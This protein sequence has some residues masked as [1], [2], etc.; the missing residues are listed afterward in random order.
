[1]KQ[2]LEFTELINH[3]CTKPKMWT[4]GGSY[5]EVFAYITG[6]ANGRNDSPIS[7]DRWNSF[8]R[9]VCLKYSFPTNYIWG[10]VIKASVQG[11]DEAIKLIGKTI[12][13]FV[14]L[15][16]RMSEADLMVYAKSN[17]QCIP[18]GEA[19]RSFRKF[20]KALLQGHEE[21][22]K[23]LIEEHPEAPIL[24]KDSYPSDVTILLEGLT[25]NQ[26]VKR[27][28]ES[29]DGK[30]I[31]VVTSDWPFPIEINFKDGHWRVNATDIIKM[32]M[33]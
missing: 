30:S 20:N 21:V 6:Y 9:Y 10:Y 2:D 23:S 25:D 18:E 12:L 13:E 17:S 7:G 29:A 3:L 15:Q 22:I 8:S 31:Q 5:N 4:L 16:G 28:F 27:V 24:W 32:R 26:P 33:K 1:M 11:E 19:E 14:E